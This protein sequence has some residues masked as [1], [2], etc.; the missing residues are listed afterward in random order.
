MMVPSRLLIFMRAMHHQKLFYR[1][2]SKLKKRSVFLFSDQ[3]T[4]LPRLNSRLK[5]QGLN[6]VIWLLLEGSVHQE[7]SRRRSACQ[8][9]KRLFCCTTRPFLWTIKNPRPKVVC[10]I[11]FLEII[12]ATAN[13]G[14]HF[15]IARLF[16]SQMCTDFGIIYPQKRVSCLF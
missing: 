13:F 11:L 10:W 3:L 2:Y 16:H 12:F 9:L 8:Y 15:G 7:V 1:R 4:L 14:K 5:D 6:C